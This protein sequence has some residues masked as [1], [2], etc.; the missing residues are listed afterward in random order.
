MGAL[1]TMADDQQIETPKSSEMDF[2]NLMMDVIIRTIA[3]DFSW[4]GQNFGEGITKW[5]SVPHPRSR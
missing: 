3:R 1:C 2:P 5:D 4:N